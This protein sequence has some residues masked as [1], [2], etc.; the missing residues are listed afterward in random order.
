M[1]IVGEAVVSIEVPAGVIVEL[2]IIREVGTGTILKKVG[3]D[4][5]GPKV[6]TVRRHERDNHP[7]ENATVRTA[8][9][10]LKVRVLVDSLTRKKQ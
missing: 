6:I 10:Y 2:E 5:I 7:K 3:E 1:M 4:S 9:L 8:G